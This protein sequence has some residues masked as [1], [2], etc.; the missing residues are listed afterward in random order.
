MNFSVVPSDKFKKEAKRLIKKCPSL[1]AEL[2]ALA[3]T[4]SAD[5]ASGTALGDGMY[6]IRLAIKSKGQGKSGGAR[7]VTY[8]V[9][10]DGEVYLLTIYD[11]SALDSIDDKTLGQIIKTL[12]K[13]TNR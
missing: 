2:A 13:H 8:V 11:K 12:D 6:K 7:V 5:P 3:Q 10:E 4:L 1:K 9:M